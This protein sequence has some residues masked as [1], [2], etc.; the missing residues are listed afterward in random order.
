MTSVTFTTFPV[1]HAYSPKAWDTFT[2]LPFENGAYS[3]ASV[4]GNARNIDRGSRRKGSIVSRNWIVCVLRLWVLRSSAR[5][6]VL[7]PLSGTNSFPLVAV[8]HTK[9]VGSHFSTGVTGQ[10]GIPKRAQLAGRWTPA[11]SLLLHL[12]R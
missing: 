10:L 11:G 2:K 1:E 7:L 3:K 8:N 6:A 5:G 4:S 9:K 12:G